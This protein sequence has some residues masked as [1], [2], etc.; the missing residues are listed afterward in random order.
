[1]RR[2]VDYLSVDI[3]SFDLWVLRAILA[4]YRPRL[5]TIEYNSNIPRYPLAFPDPKLM[6]VPKGERHW[7]GNC[8]MGSSALAL[9]MVAWAHNY[10]VVDVEPGLD[11]FLVPAEVWRRTGQAE[12][13]LRRETQRYYRPFN[14]GRDG[15]MKDFQVAQYID[16]AEWLRTGSHE[17]AKE[18]ARARTDRLAAEGVPC[19]RHGNPPDCKILQRCPRLWS[20]LC[21]RN[22]T[23]PC[24]EFG[25]RGDWISPAHCSVPNPKASRCPLHECSGVKPRGAMGHAKPAN[26]AEIPRCVAAAKAL[27]G[28]ASRDALAALGAL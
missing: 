7:G 19:F 2:D 9:Q 23:D 12:L 4:A 27:D 26:L 24:V 10:S 14:V 16:Y 6:D 13:D 20:F 15:G 17:R 11:L 3:D 22:G 21:R 1:M 25:D 28:E 18:R 8:Y 5:I